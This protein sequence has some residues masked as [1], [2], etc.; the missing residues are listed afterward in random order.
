MEGRDGD[1]RV[2]ELK[3][4]PNPCNLPRGC[5]SSHVDHHAC[6]GSLAGALRTGRGT[7]RAKG[8]RLGHIMYYQL[9]VG[10]SSELCRE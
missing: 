4:V 7:P 2:T 9:L 8:P 1:P 10:L 3:E 5:R 6:L